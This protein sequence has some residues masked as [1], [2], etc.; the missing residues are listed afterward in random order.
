MSQTIKITIPSVEQDLEL[1]KKLGHIVFKMDQLGDDESITKVLLE[2]VRNKEKG[3]R[4][5]ETKN[6]ATTKT[7]TIRYLNER[8]EI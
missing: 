6:T 5:K 2:H 3:D 7:T 4:E 8:S 1:F